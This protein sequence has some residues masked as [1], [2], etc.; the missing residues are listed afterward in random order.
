MVIMA[1]IRIH[2]YGSQKI[3]KTYCSLKFYYNCGNIIFC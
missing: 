3:E 2:D 1:I